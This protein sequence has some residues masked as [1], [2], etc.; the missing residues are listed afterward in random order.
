MNNFKKNII[1]IIISFVISAIITLAIE[2]VIK[3]TIWFSN[4]LSIM[5]FIL[6]VMLIIN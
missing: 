3:Q 4:L 5:K 1:L 6:S 2:E